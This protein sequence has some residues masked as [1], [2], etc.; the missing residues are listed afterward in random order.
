MLTSMAL[1]SH[2]HCVQFPP[3]LPL[4]NVPSFFSTL[5]ILNGVTQNLKV[6]RHFD[7][8][9]YLIF[10]EL[11]IQFIMLVCWLDNFACPT[12]AM[13]SI[14]E[15][16]ITDMVYNWQSFFHS[17]VSLLLLIIASFPA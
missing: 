9:L 6:V 2:V 7:K 15:I 5:A 16:F 13:L 8:Y 1:H 14:I 12:F 17:I 3:S 11:S 4:K 10:L